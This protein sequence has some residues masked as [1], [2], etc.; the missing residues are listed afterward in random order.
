M[1]AGLDKRHSNQHRTLKKVLLVYSS[2]P[3]IM[4]YLASALNR[5]G[6]AAEMDV[7]HGLL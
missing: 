7:Y 6:I 5:K 2:K 4:Q 1:K 3:P